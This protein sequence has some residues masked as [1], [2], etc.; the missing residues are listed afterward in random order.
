M[1]VTNV[2][3]LWNKPEKLR[4]S[5][6]LFRRNC[7]NETAVSDSP[8][9]KTS[10]RAI[11]MNKKTMTLIIIKRVTGFPLLIFSWI[12]FNSGFAIIT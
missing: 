5:E 11:E 6:K 7:S 2:Q 10:I 8:L 3:G 9:K 1:Y 4:G 12:S